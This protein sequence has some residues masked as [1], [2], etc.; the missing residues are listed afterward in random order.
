M[1]NQKWERR[2]C[3]IDNF[4]CSLYRK[5]YYW[6]KV[7]WWL[8]KG[9]YLKISTFLIWSYTFIH[10]HFFGQWHKQFHNVRLADKSR[11]LKFESRN[12]NIYTFR[13]SH[14]TSFCN[15]QI[16]QCRVPTWSG[17]AAIHSPWSTVTGVHESPAEIDVATINFVRNKTTNVYSRKK[18]HTHATSFPLL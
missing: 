4:N 6:V 7:L 10:F 1:Y 13:D 8:K 16:C 9:T 3:C 5:Y 15:S 2:F 18:K 12:I 14:D 17:K 11:H